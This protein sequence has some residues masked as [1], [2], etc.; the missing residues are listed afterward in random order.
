MSKKVILSVVLSVALIF[1]VLVLNSC[2]ETVDVGT[3][4]HSG[5]GTP[6]ADCGKIGDFYF[7]TDSYDVWQKDDSGWTVIANIKGSDGAT[8][9]QGETGPQGPQG[10]K[11]EQ[12]I[13]G[14]IGPQGV[15]GP[16]GGM[17]ATGATGATGPQGPKGDKG[18]SG[19]EDIT[20]VY[21]GYGGVIWCDNEKTQ[22]SV[23]F[24]DDDVCEDTIGLVGDM[25]K[26]FP[27][28]YINLSST[29]VALM[30]YYMRATN[31]TL[32][33]GLA[34]KEISV[35]AKD[36]GV[37]YIGTANVA[38]VANAR[39]SGAAYTAKTIAYSVVAGENVITFD[40]PIYVGDNETIV[41]GGDGS[42]SL[43]YAKNVPVDDE[44]G[45]FALLNGFSN[46][47]VVSG[48]Q[49]A[50]TLAIKVRFDTT[51]TAVD[52]PIVPELR[53]DSNGDTVYARSVASHLTPFAY[54]YNY[55]VYEEKQITKVGLPVVSVKAIDEN[56]QFTIHVVNVNGTGTLKDNIVKSYKLTLPV[57]QLGTDKSAVKKW[58]Y[59]DTSELGI[60]VGKG[61]TVAFG[62]SADTVSWGYGAPAVS[63]KKY[64]FFNGNMAFTANMGTGSETGIFFDL[65]YSVSISVDIEDHIA[66]LIEENEKALENNKSLQLIEALRE[67]GINNFSILGDSISTYNGY[68]NGSTVAAETNST[69]G[70]NGCWYYTSRGDMTSAEYTWWYMASQECETPILVNNSYSGDQLAGSGLGL[71]RCE[72]LHDDTGSNA[73]TNPDFIA[74]FF[75]TNDLGRN[76]TG[77]NFRTLYTQMVDKMQAKYKDADIF[78]FT[79]LPVSD[80]D[81]TPAELVEYNNII[82]EIA[83]AK[84]CYVVDI[85]ANSG[86]TWDNYTEKTIDGTHPNR[87]GM[88]LIKE[89]F[90]QALY[91]AYVGKKN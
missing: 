40:N 61:Q 88:E 68:T 66:T 71:S 74:V 48:D 37:L 70:S 65:Y 84:G 1:G 49:Y 2:G 77:S 64:G 47:N 90:L 32:Y 4:W 44:D 25:S 86:I 10:E 55:E 8:G 91:D 85:C 87:A 57:D 58:I 14:E 63:T 20:K 18:D 13:Q 39:K 56:Q 3:I 35:F 16:Q 75:G 43:Y 9:P 53:S 45:N 17:G 31:K 46:M 79:L 23:G 76:V 24:Q 15:Q 11:G 67:K 42:V 50:D 38:D 12:G 36:A 69:I 7:E 21:I 62:D 83:V 28:E 78:L 5:E 51:G 54:K 29:R 26:V 19:I 59:I 73:G 81:V 22:I 33:S 52:T 89:T 80:T 82:K 41:L 72:Q 27:G 30:S 60:Y 34:V 6:T